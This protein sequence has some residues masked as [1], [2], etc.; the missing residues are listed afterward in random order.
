[1]SAFNSKIQ[2]HGGNVYRQH[3]R[4][5]VTVWPKLCLSREFY[6]WV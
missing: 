6:R 3:P 4:R 5:S 1:M 2:T